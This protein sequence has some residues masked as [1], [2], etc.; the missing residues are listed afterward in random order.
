MQSVHEGYENKSFDK[1]SG[2]VTRAVCKESGLLPNEFCS[3]DPRGS[4]VYNEIFVKGTVP[5][6]TCT[7]HVQVDIDTT[8]GKMATFFTPPEF[9]VQKVVIKRDEPY[10]PKAN[11]D[12]VPKDYI[13]SWDSIQLDE[14]VILPENPEIIVP[15]TEPNST[16]NG[17]SINET[18]ESENDEPPAWL[19]GPSD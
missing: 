11:R 12:F 9:T 2:I 8:T 19:F 6:D 16:E 5:T 1:P 14:N 10:D 18:S 7:T 4:S 15:I 17:N 3:L 13:Y